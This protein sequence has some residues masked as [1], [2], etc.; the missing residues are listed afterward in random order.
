[1]ADTNKIK[2][3]IEPF[4]RGW[5]KTRVGETTLEERSVAFP[6]GGSYKFDAVSR[7]GRFIGAI[8]CN[9][10]RTRNGNENTGGVRKAIGEIEHLK[11]V[12]E[13]AKKYM[14]FTDQDFLELIRRRAARFGVGNI[15]FV[16]CPLPPFLRRSLDSILDASSNEQFGQK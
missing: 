3:E 7:D 16:Y 15:E 14:V 9:R 13:Q 1:M 2:T 6:T 12:G 11:L 4:I 8:L 10:A 5:L